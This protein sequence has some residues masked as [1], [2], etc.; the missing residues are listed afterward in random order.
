M[1]FD[2]WQLDERLTAVSADQQSLM[3]RSW[4]GALFHAESI[5]KN[6]LEDM[7]YRFS[8]VVDYATNGKASKTNYDLE[9][10]KSL[11]EEAFRERENQAVNDALEIEREAVVGHLERLAGDIRDGSLEI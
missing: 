10:Y 3:E 7:A 4:D 6:E 5:H 1:T 8:C 2:E 9:T 11:I